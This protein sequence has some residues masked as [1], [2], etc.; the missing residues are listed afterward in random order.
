MESKNQFGTESEDFSLEENEEGMDGSR[1]G[2][3]AIKFMKILMER[4]SEPWDMSAG[5]IEKSRNGKKCVEM[6]GVKSGFCKKIKAVSSDTIPV[7]KEEIDINIRN[8]SRYRKIRGTQISN[9]SN[10]IPGI[11]IY[12]YICCTVLFLHFTVGE[13]VNPLRMVRTNRLEENSFQ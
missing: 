6:E 8:G 7:R 10:S 12:L 3:R 13:E 1:N 11:Y 4:E 5:G 9:G 2:N